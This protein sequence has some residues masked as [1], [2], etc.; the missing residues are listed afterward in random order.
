MTSPIIDT[1]DYCETRTEVTLRQIARDEF[2]AICHPCELRKRILADT[3]FDAQ[4]EIAR[5]YPNG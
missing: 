3:N 2:E 4:T 5:E 1:C